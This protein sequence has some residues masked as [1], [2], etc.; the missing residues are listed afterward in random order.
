MEFRLAKNKL[1]LI[2]PSLFLAFSWA[3]CD[4]MSSGLENP[5]SYL[6]VGLLLN[7]LFHNNLIKN[8]KKIFIILSLIVLN[9]YDLGLLFLPLAIILVISYLNRK[10]YFDILWIGVLILV[11]WV[12]FSIIYFGTP[13]PNTYFAKLNSNYPL[14]EVYERGIQYYIALFLDFNSII[15]I[16][17]GFL[18]FLLYRDKIIFSL[19]IGKILYLFY[20]LHAGGDFMQGRFFSVVLFLS[21][22]E[23][24]FA[25]SKCKKAHEF[26]N[27]LVLSLLLLIVCFSIPLNAPIYAKT[28]Y[29]SRRTFKNIVDERGIYFWH[30]GLLS[31]HRS[32]WPKYLLLEEETP[33]KYKL[34]CGALGVNSLID[35]TVIHI[36]TCGLADPYLSRI[37]ATRYPNWR[38]G[39]HN[40]KVPFEYGLFKTG[41]LE[42][43]PDENLQSMFADISIVTKGELFTLQRFKAIWRLMRNSYPNQ[44][45]AKYIDPNIWI[46]LTNS[47]D[48]FIIP[49]WE[50]DIMNNNFNHNLEYNARI[51]K[52]TSAIWVRIDW[53]HSYDIYINDKKIHTLL[54]HGKFCEYGVKIN[55][56]TKQIVKSIKFMTVDKTN[57]ANGGFNFL[58]LLRLGR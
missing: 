6:L 37:P 10:N 57:F 18:S 47:I 41:K 14:I 33:D 46:P 12:L 52:E 20:V 7:Y 40:R 30:T 48:K 1:L 38:I 24:I 19:L 15:I 56:P 39:H 17:T 31:V 36:D 3:F 2:S 9:R 8:L 42:K 29:D 55:L 26:K 51:P 13:F 21:I 45:F 54:K 22:G 34:L 49:N 28:D 50:L 25:I 44:D 5:L 4:Y 16:S 58:E 11:G 27:K 43:I 23:F 32:G 53:A 35:N